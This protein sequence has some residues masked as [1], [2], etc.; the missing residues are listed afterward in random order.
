MS[1]PKWFWVYTKN[2]ACLKNLSML[3]LNFEKADGLG[4]SSKTAPRILIFW[5]RACQRSPRNYYV[6]FFSNK[7]CDVCPI[8]SYY[9]IS[10]MNCYDCIKSHHKGLGQVKT[11]FK[12]EKRIEK[13]MKKRNEKKRIRWNRI[14]KKEAKGKTK[15]K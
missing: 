8:T 7:V 10:D 4:I 5:L 12:M 6:T 13:D 14:E 9:V 2:W 11:C 15:E 3:K 1:I